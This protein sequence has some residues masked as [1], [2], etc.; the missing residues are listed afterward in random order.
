MTVIISLKNVR[1]FERNTTQSFSTSKYG[2]KM[3]G[4]NQGFLARD[5]GWRN[6]KMLPKVY[7]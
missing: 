6:S 3:C 7:R 4:N 2:T 1:L 5:I